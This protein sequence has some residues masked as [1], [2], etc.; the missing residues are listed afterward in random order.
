MVLFKNH[1]LS[2]TFSAIKIYN[3]IKKLLVDNRI[4]ASLYVDVMGIKLPNY[5]DNLTN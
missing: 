3:I 4:F 2:V 5:F 1:I